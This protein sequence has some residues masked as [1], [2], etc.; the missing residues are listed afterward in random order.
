MHNV[1]PVHNIDNYSH[2][3]IQ[4]ALTHLRLMQSATTEK[5]ARIRI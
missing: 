5:A 4:K 1:T 2:L 3:V